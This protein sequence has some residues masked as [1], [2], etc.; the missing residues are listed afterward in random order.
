MVSTKTIRV[1]PGDTIKIKCIEPLE[2]GVKRRVCEHC[3]KSY[4]QRSSL[5][6]HKKIC[7]KKDR[8]AF[9]DREVELDQVLIRKCNVCDKLF[10]CECLIEEHRKMCVYE[11]DSED[12]EESND[13]DDMEDD[14][15]SEPSGE[16]LGDLD[17][18]IEDVFL[19]PSFGEDLN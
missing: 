16:S 6:R 13:E 11:E 8:C 1:Q 12:S 9:C 3:S 18:G 4:A 19:P 10:Y 17:V 2:K 14:E 15:E 5:S 7:K